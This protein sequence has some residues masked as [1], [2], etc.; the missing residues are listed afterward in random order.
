MRCQSCWRVGVGVGCHGSV[1]QPPL[2]LAPRQPAGGWG[3]SRPVQGLAVGERSELPLIHILGVL[4]EDLSAHVQRGPLVL[5]W[6]PNSWQ[7]CDLCHFSA[8]RAHCRQRR[9]QRWLMLAGDVLPSGPACVSSHGCW[10]QLTHAHARFLTSLIHRPR[11]WS[12]AF[13]LC[14]FPHCLLAKKGQAVWSLCDSWW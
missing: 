12:H 4:A 14:M 5:K 2:R 6:S 1:K 9:V 10:F 11:L 13:P 7:P 3:S 8:G